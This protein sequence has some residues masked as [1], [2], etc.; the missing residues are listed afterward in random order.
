MLFFLAKIQLHMLCF[1]KSLLCSHTVWSTLRTIW[2]DA[3]R[4]G[5][6]KNRPQTPFRLLTETAILGVLVIEETREDFR[7]ALTDIG[8]QARPLQENF[9]QS[10]V[11]PIEQPILEIGS[12]SDNLQLLDVGFCLDDGIRLVCSLYC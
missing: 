2:Y 11:Q 9:N 4:A 5:F 6:S 8:R 10:N 12:H 1:E 3:P 7:E